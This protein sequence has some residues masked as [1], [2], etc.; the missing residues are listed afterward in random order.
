[1]LEN[2]HATIEALVG[3][4][5]SQPG[6]RFMDRLIGQTEGPPMDGHHIAPLHILEGLQGILGIT[7]HL[8][9]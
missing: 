5:P 6:G 9:K 3:A 4:Q 1:M 2:L 7:V 8:P